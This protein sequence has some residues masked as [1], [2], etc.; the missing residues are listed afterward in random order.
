MLLI[1]KKD[2]ERVEQAFNGVIKHIQQHY[3]H[4]NIIV[5]AHVWRK[6][7]RTFP[8]LYTFADG[9]L[10]ERVLFVQMIRLL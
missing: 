4:L 8:S 6:L 2:D 9:M 3:P 5:E 7:A 1:K 10:S